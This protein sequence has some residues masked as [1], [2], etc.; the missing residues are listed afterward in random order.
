MVRIS[1]LRRRT[2]EVAVE[3]AAEVDVE[4]L[5]PGRCQDGEAL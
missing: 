1:D 4:E 2:L 3:A 5:P